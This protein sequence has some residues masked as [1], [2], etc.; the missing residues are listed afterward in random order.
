MLAANRFRYPSLSLTNSHKN[1]SS[2]EL[3][4]AVA[5]FRTSFAGVG[6]F[7]AA[8][9][10]LMLIG[11][12]FMLQVYDRVLA[13]RS[14]ATLLVLFLIVVFLY[15]I[16]GVLDHYRGRV[17]ARIGAGVQSKLDQRVFQLVL[18]QAEHPTL[19]DRPAGALKDLAT[20]RAAL[21]SPA[22]GAVFDLPWTPFYIGVMFLF[23]PWLGW[24]SVASTL[25]IF[26][27]AVLNEVKTRRLHAEAGQQS[28]QA[29]TQ[30]ERIRHAIETVR[31]LG[32]VS[33][34]TGRWRANRDAALQTNLKAVD[35]G[36]LLSTTT[37]TI[38][39]LLQS[40]VL[41]LGALLVL[42]GQ[43]TPGTMIAGSILLGR[44]LAPV[45]QVVGQWLLF[46]R[47]AA[48]WK[49][50]TT[51]L[52]QFSVDKALTELPRPE[53]KLSVE[54]LTVIPP[55]ETSPVLQGV[56][57]SAEPGDAIGIIGPS[58]S[59]KTSL[60]RALV[61]FWKPANGEIRLD[62]ADLHQYESDR[63]GHL[64]GY[65]P[66]DV[67]VFSGTVAENIAR[68][69]ENADSDQVIKASKLAAAHELVLGLPEG[70][71][72]EVSAGGRLSGGQRQRIGLARAFYGDPVML[73]LDEPN[74]SLDEAGIRALSQAITNARQ[75]G[76]IVLVISHRPSALAECNKVL[77]LDE[78]QMRA[79]GPREQV[80]DQVVR[81][82]RKTVK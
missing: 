75:Q 39:L 4:K 42:R 9:N 56:S 54:N 67:K 17:L 65:L 34:M 48:S 44:A 53:A 59:G 29:D 61:G 1:Q 69:E 22:T 74:S 20:I 37:K 60:A 16:M 32:M 8:V 3:R 30:T 46:Q 25:L 10:L 78:G 43:L 40:A 26:V 57:F 82:M 64:L 62:G 51:L 27:L 73:V 52:G 70:Y 19:R 80:L 41:A 2:Q 66:Q 31:G 21:S 50:L 77:M 5:E 18:R 63:L 58:S 49:T 13:S 7:S 6:V 68:F 12:L 14:T 36:G 24:F 71:D 55:G 76:K 15:G 72:T 35:T 45:D 81:P 23:H 47:A 28:A 33:I 38:R 79:F 11:P